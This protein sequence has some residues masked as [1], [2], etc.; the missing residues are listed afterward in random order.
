MLN[1]KK[2]VNK[3]L[4]AVRIIKISFSL[5]LANF[6][7]HIEGSYL[8]I[9]W[10]LLSPLALFVVILFIK[11]S[12]FSNHEITNY[13]IYLI[14]GITGL[15]FF[16]QVISRSI[17]IIS[18]QAS[19]IK[20]MSGIKP[21]ILVLASVFQSTFSHLFEFLMVVGFLI[22]FKISLLGLLLYPLLLFFFV[23]LLLGIALIF[24]TIG[25]YIRDLDNIWLVFSQLLLLVTPIFYIAKSD[26]LIYKFNL[27]N[28]LFYFLEIFRGLTIYENF[29]PFWMIGVFVFIS[30]TI[31]II[32]WLIFNRYSKKFAE[33]V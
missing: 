11:N 10:Y 13:P 12:A 6:R 17:N 18:S 24:S 23:L 3:F 30:S 19:Y 33:L 21:L 31:F 5:A 4:E 28:P 15:H 7:L 22:Y 25:V 14:I 27:F 20:S 32:G 8:G 2:P 1:R 29:P 16:Q 26:S 9:F